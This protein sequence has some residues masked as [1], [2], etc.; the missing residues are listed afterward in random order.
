MLLWNTGLYCYLLYRNVNPPL[1][2]ETPYRQLNWLYLVWVN[3]W[4]LLDP[5][6]LCP[7]WRFGT[8]PLIESTLDPRNLVTM[9]TFVCLAYLA[10]RGLAYSKKLLFGLTWMALT[11]LPASNVFFPVGFVVAERVLYLPSLGYCFIVGYG[12]T[13]AFKTLRSAFVRFLTAST[14]IVLICLM[15]SRTVLRNEDWISNVSL[16]SSGARCN[17]NNGVMLTNLGIQH[18]RLKNFT[19]AEKLYR[20]SMKVAPKHSRGY[21]NFGGLMEARKRYGEAEEVRQGF[22]QD[23]FFSWGGRGGGAHVAKYLF[24][25]THFS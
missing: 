6:F 7:D 8:V 10:W 4:Q 9:A 16:Y 22:I 25:H 5:N 23:F 2:M 12:F 13:I 3:L 24:D 15:A 18:G 17:P 20:R 11:F 21:S 19:F 14:F 1:F